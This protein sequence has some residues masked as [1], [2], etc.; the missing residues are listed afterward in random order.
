MGKLFIV[1]APSGAGKT[2]LVNAVI[3]WV[4]PKNP[5]KR[6]ITYTSKIARRGEQN[7]RDYHFLSSTE[8]EQKI[9]D[10]FF[11]EYSIAY[12]AYYGSPRSVLDEIKQGKSF[13]LII[14]RIGAKQVV[15]Q[16]KCEVLIWIYPPSIEVLKQR[17]EYRATENSEQIQKRIVQAQKEIAQE[18]S[19]KLYTYHVKNDVFEKAVQKLEAII[20]NELGNTEGK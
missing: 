18:T 1:S 3:K 6:V 14:D 9:K 17:L 10:G 2:T 8:F 19:Q 4:C 15:K 5:I 20:I 16:T 11:L 13:I 7:E 12:G